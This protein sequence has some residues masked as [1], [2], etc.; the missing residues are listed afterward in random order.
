[1]FIAHGD[2]RLGKAMTFDFDTLFVLVA[3]MALALGEVVAEFLQ[4]LPKRV[5]H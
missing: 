2:R 4:R 5:R 1:V 3:L